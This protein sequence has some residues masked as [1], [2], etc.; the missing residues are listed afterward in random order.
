[1]SLTVVYIHVLLVKVNQFLELYLIPLV[2]YRPFVNVPSNHT[3]G[4]VCV[5][6][7]HAI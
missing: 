3:F 4:H 1:M 5:I 2:K 7:S 6:M